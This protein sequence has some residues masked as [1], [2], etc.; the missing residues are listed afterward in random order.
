MIL[1]LLSD[2]LH[3]SKNKELLALSVN[4]EACVVAEELFITRSLRKS[5]IERMFCLNLQQALTLM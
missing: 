4:S 2:C 3:S 1:K 5:V